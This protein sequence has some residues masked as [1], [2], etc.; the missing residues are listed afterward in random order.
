M[1]SVSSLLTRDEAL[2]EL[3]P[4]VLLTDRDSSQLHLDVLGWLVRE[5]SA[6]GC[7]PAGISARLRESCA[8]SW[9]EVSVKLPRFGR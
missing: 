2:L 7:R 9:A 4:N 8:E 6:S 1:R 3:V 5:S